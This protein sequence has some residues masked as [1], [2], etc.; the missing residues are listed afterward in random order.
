[1]R[2]VWAAV[3]V[4]GLMPSPILA[5]DALRLF[6]PVPSSP[7]VPEAEARTIPMVRAALNEAP[8]APRPAPQIRSTVSEPMAP[9]ALVPETAP[10]T[11]PPAGAAFS[12]APP[13]PIPRP[14]IPSTMSE[15]KAPDDPPTPLARPQYEAPPASFADGVTARFD[16]PYSTLP[17]FR[18]LTLDIY[19]PRPQSMP[20]PLVLFVHGG[21]WNAGDSRTS[22]AFTDFPR[23]LAALAAQGYV[24]ASINYRLSQEA[25]FPAALQDV[26]SAIRWMRGHAV[27]YGGDPTRLAIWG[28]S[29]GGQLAAMAGVTCGVAGFEPEGEVSR[30]APS[31]CAEAVIDWY[32]PTDLQTLAADNARDGFSAAVATPSP[33]GRYLGCEIA[34][35]PPGVVRMASPL[36]FI[37]ESAPPF[38]IQQGDP[39]PEVSPKQAQKLYD[40]LKQKGVPAELVLYPGV[41]HQFW[42][43]DAPDAATVAKAMAK[44]T[45]FLAATFPNKSKPQIRRTVAN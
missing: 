13:M 6:A 12:E 7:P 40:A 29:A 30:D 20:A 16:I 19:A 41:G 44:V 22:R 37:S 8:P 18:P 35:C 25:R 5:Q 11:V 1:M 38:L 31:N 4:V 2:A 26:K 34:A 24:V 33:E 45:S 17:G 36:A 10:R 28:A 15:P 27:S 39:D 9:Y 43:K 42:R 14:Q 3:V 23:A 21:S 32:G